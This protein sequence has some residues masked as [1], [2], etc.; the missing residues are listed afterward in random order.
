MK[1]KRKT[2]KNIQVTR[3]TQNQQTKHVKWSMYRLASCI[4]C[5]VQVEWCKFFAN[6]S[7][8]SKTSDVFECSHW[9]LSQLLPIQT[10][11]STQP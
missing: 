8:S 4:S 2:K 5:N 6:E 3:Q 9:Q 1:T 10:F 7:S 11:T